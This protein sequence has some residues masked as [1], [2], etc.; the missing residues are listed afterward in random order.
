MLAEAAARVFPCLLP[1]L[2]WPMLAVVAVQAALVAV[3]VVAAAA[4]RA[5]ALVFLVQEMALQTEV[6]VA[7]ELISTAVSVLP[8]LV[9]LELL[10]LG[11]RHHS[12]LQIRAAA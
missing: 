11:I 6:A 2:P 5:V 1:G 4:A 3:L 12:R 10:F 9:V 8:G 7:A